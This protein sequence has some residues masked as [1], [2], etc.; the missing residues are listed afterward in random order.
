MVSLLELSKKKKVK[1]NDYTAKPRIHWRYRTKE[2]KALLKR[3]LA[4]ER[5]ELEDA[6][7]N[8]FLKRP[9][10]VDLLNNPKYQKK[11]KKLF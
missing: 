3:E 2:G 1:K 5:K 8:E 10:I 4:Q 7:F 6:F 9:D 11:K